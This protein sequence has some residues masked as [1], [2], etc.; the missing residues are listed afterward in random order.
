[1][2]RT[3]FG[4]VLKSL[5]CLLVFFLFGGVGEGGGLKEEAKETV[6]MLLMVLFG[7]ELVYWLRA[8]KKKV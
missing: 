2:K 4:C 8:S 1:M 3:C 5:V 7:I 6:L